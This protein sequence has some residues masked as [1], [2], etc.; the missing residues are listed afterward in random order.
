LISYKNS[1]GRETKVIADSE[2][3][4]S[5]KKGRVDGAGGINRYFGEGKVNGVTLEVGMLGSTEMAG[6]PELMKQEQ[7]FLD[8]LSKAKQY[9]IVGEQLRLNKADGQVI[10]KFSPHKEAALAAGKEKGFR[11]ERI[12]S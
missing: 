3:T 9:L 5:F 8:Q 12:I 6:P 2:T 4:L 10:L 7:V 1:A 11:T